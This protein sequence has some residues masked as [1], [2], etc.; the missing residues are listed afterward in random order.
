MKIH[1]KVLLIML[2]VVIFNKVSGMQT[3][4]IE[5][6]KTI[7]TSLSC[8]EDGTL[9]QKIATLTAWLIEKKNNS[10]DNEYHDLIATLNTKIIIPDDSHYAKGYTFRK[11]HWDAL[12]RCAS[13]IEHNQDHKQLLKNIANDLFN[14]DLGSQISSLHLGGACREPFF[15]K[16]YFDNVH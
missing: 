15:S 1:M 9:P 13:N 6:A 12:V 4:L 14:I 11:I 5:H 8:I 10:H 3:E 7:S 2:S 16:E